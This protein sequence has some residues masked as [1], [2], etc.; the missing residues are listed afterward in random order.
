[1]FFV[2]H[3][4]EGMLVKVEINDE[5]VFTICPKCG[6]EHKVNLGFVLCESEMD[7]CGTQVFCEK[8]SRQ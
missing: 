2:K 5:N 8:C 3:E 6:K 4:T 1:M 7:L